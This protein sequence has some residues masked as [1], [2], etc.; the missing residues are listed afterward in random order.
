M[1]KTFLVPQINEGFSEE[2]YQLKSKGETVAMRCSKA[3]H[4]Q[5]MQASGK[6][7]KKK[8]RG[9]LFWKKQS[10]VR[11]KEKGGDHRDKRI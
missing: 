8:H 4:R 9:T 10:D 11:A 1:P 5:A 2:A 7:R 3:T 6:A